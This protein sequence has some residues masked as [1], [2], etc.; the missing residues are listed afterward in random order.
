MQ[1]G[2]EEHKKKMSTGLKLHV[3]GIRMK[4]KATIACG[5]DDRGAAGGVQL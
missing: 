3:C 1:N 4:V 5:E 2:K